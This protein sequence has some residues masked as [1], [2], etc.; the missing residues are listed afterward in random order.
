VLPVA[1]GISGADALEPARFNDGFQMAVLIAAVL[2]AAGGL[3]SWFFIRN[4]T[5]QPAPAEPVPATEAA[6]PP[7]DRHP[8]SCPVTAPP[9]RQPA[10]APE[11]R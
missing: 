5:P 11:A 9:V 2:C 4:P 6:T 10:P 3:I 1:A 8:I 7:E